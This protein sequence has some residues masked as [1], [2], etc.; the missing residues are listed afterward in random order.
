MIEFR[1]ST[2]YKTVITWQGEHCS[3]IV[4]VGTVDATSAV[5]LNLL[6]QKL[7]VYPD[8]HLEFNEFKCAIVQWH[9]E[10]YNTR[11]GVLRDSL[12]SAALDRA[13]VLNWDIHAYNHH[14]AVMETAEESKAA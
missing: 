5:Q 10:L 13:N 8:I 7:D 1:P 4:D 14:C 2:D 6:L 11:N 9:K 3:A 12:V